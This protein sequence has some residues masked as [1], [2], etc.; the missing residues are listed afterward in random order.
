[1][2]ELD[3][4]KLFQNNHDPAQAIKQDPLS[5]LTL[6]NVPGIGAVRLRALLGAFGTPSRVLNAG[7]NSLC[8]VPGIDTVT[9]SAIRGI[10]TNGEAEKILSALELCSARMVSIWDEEYPK[11]LKEIH[12]PPAILFIRGI[13]PD[14]KQPTLAIVGTRD[15]SLYGIQQSHRIAEELAQQGIN[16]VSGMARGVDTSAHEGCLQGNGLTYAVFG[17]GIDHIYPPENRSLAE[18]IRG[19]GGLISEFPPGI[20]PDPGLFPRRNRLISGLSLGVL[21]VQG[22]LKSGALI[23][24]RCA[25]EHNRE[26]F[27]LPGSVEDRRSRGPHSLIREGATL[28]NNAKDI[29]ESLGTEFDGELEETRQRNIAT[30]ISSEQNLIIKLSHEPIHIDQLVRELKLPVQS[31][32]ADLLGLEMKGLINQLPGKL[33]VLK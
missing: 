26:V 24:A 9:A 29:L 14:S 10:K 17:C 31:V 2:S 23:T 20:Q 19:N 30:L 3:Q 5:L 33:F 32:L 6:L 13:L 28:I 27:A 18:K 7:V 22:D 16:I 21:V 11:I 4:I 25:L 12:D 15:P 8:G 1:M